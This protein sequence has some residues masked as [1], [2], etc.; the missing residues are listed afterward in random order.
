MN[1]I[2]MPIYGMYERI[3]K[4]NDVISIPEMQC[5]LIPYVSIYSLH[6]HSQTNYIYRKVSLLMAGR[7][8]SENR[9]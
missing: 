8:Y 1:K 9:K 5:I 4:L 2:L 7:G 6:D 3:Y